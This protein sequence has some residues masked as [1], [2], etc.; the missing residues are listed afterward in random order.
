[1]SKLLKITSRPKTA[2]DHHRSTKAFDQ[3]SGQVYT[4]TS[5]RECS[6][7]ADWAW[8]TIGSSRDA[9][10]FRSRG[11]GCSSLTNM[12]I[13]SALVNSLSITPENLKTVPWQV[14]KSL[15]KRIVTSY[16]ESVLNP[17]Q[18]DDLSCRPVNWIAS[19]YGKYLHRS[20]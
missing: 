15:W 18:S 13:R 16:V 2:T 4:E 20:I 3:E 6:M 19:V 17:S 10:R 1:M 14:G 11:P 12:A 8:K 7:T 9:R 5:T